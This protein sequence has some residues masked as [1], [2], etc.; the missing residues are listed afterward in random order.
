[1]EKIINSFKRL[2]AKFYISFLKHREIKKFRSKK[3]KKI[4]KT[5][6]LT[7]DQ[8]K[9]IDFYFKKYYGKKIPYIWHRHYTAFTGNFDYRYMPELLHIPLL[10]NVISRKYYQKAME[11]KNNL[12]FLTQ[13]TDFIRTPR[14][15][16]SKINGIYR[17]G[18]L[19]L[20]S[21][22]EAI[23]ILKNIGHC[24]IKPSID[25]SSGH[26]CAILD[27][28]DGVDLVSKADVELILKKY[29]SDFIVQEKIVPNKVIGIFNPASVNTFRV[30]TYILKD[31]TI[32][33]TPTTFRM[34]RNNSF[35]D[36]AHAGGIF[37][38]VDDEGNFGPVAFTE[39]NQR[40]YEHP[41]S[42]VKFEGYKV[43]QFPSILAAAKS[44][45]ALIPQIR[46]VNWDITINEDGEL[47]LMEANMRGGSA[48]LPQMSSGKGMFGDDIWELL[49]EV[50]KK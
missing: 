5:V 9:Q 22:Q 32:K 50:K 28:K 19:Q 7:K 43:E 4:Y 17:N 10:E 39:F 35:L 48:W 38:S 12:F 2:Y 33:N 25:S 23:A 18:D 11:D 46:I 15:F 42:H 47:I 49:S 27:L 37:L 36:N 1:M 41:D 6:T 8:K 29:C 14:T 40:F 34:G 3:R 45:H 30:I 26:G 20:V 44:M 31:G 24:F 21:Y 13:K 16:L